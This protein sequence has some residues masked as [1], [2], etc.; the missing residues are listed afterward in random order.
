MPRSYSGP[1]DEKPCLVGFPVI[2]VHR[3]VLSC[4]C[5]YKNCTVEMIDYDICLNMN[6]TRQLY[7]NEI[8]GISPCEEILWDDFLL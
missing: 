6:L 4:G 5:A 3:L 1:E 2:L 8:S 7:H